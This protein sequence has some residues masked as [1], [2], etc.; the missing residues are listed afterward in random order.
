MKPYL[1]I[2]ML[3]CSVGAAGVPS[4]AAQGG[5]GCLRYWSDTVAITGILQRLVFPGRPNYESVAQG[6]EEE[7]GFYLRLT[8]PI[9]TVGDSLSPD[10]YPIASADTVQLVL[11]SAGY[12]RLRPLL[13]KQ[14]TEKGTLFARHTGHHHA[15][16]LLWVSR[17]DDG[18]CGRTA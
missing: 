18:C 6:D 9:C 8:R 1:R 12:A 13:G 10:S 14:V 17:T 16:L 2:T 3:L 15:P 5:N 11:D 4:V 7:A